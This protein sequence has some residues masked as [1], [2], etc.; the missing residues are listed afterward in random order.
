[1]NLDTLKRL[2]FWTPPILF[3][4]GAF[5]LGVFTEEWEVFIPRSIDDA[6]FLIPAFVLGPIYY[7][8]PFRNKANQSYH[9]KVQNNI[10]M[11]LLRISGFQPHEKYTWKKVRVIFLT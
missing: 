2:R 7:L 1:M 9:E 6:Q 4:A 8:T 11:N 5:L 10:I 3:I